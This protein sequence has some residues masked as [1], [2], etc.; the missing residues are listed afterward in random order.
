MEGDESILEGDESQFIA[1]E[2]FATPTPRRSTFSK[3]TSD[4]SIVGESAIPTPSGKRTS[5]SGAG[6]RIPAPGL[7]RRQSQ[8]GFG[9]ASTN[10]GA[11]GAGDGM[12]RPP[13][14]TMTMASRKKGAEGDVN[15]TF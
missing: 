3:R 12:M 2:E 14:R 15:E 7:A 8:Q 10:I 11:G 5:I 4:V 13:S 9:F 1:R 6:S